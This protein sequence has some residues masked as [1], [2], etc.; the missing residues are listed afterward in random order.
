MKIYCD[1]K[2]FKMGQETLDE[3]VQEFVD[4]QWV[5]TIESFEVDS[6]LNLITF[7]A[8]AEDPDEDD[9]VKFEKELREFVKLVLE[10]SE[11]V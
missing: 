3:I 5:I 1:E 6:D 8:W 10:D 9:K 4:N 11:G 7:H 2:L